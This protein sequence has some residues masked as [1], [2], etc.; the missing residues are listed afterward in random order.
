MRYEVDY[1]ALMG[2]AQMGQA[3]MATPW[4]PMGWAVMGQA[5]MGPP[6]P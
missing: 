2:L 6:G 4:A 3:L 1:W 5:L